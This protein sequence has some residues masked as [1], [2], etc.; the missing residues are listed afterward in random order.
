MNKEH[1]NDVPKIREDNVSFD[2]LHLEGLLN[3]I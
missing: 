2:P 3:K 1:E